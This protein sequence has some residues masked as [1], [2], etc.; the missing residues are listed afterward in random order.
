MV[1]PAVYSLGLKR[2][3]SG[4]LAKNMTM[5]TPMLQMKTV[6]AIK[7]WV[8]ASWSW[9][10]YFWIRV[11]RRMMGMTIPLFKKF[12]T[13]WGP[14]SRVLPKIWFSSQMSQYSVSVSVGSKSGRYAGS[15]IRMSLTSL[16]GSGAVSKCSRGSSSWES[17]SSLSV[18][19]LFS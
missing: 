12:I 10:Q 17:Y 1:E 13:C 15:S 8:I 19:N 5:I 6:D 14:F 7:N 18:S 2:S 16:D 3:K 9:L 4:F 11:N